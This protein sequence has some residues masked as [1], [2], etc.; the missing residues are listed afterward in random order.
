MQAS[1]VKVSLTA[2]ESAR[3]A[4]SDELKKEDFFARQRLLPVGTGGR[5][6]LTDDQSPRYGMQLLDIVAPF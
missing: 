2:G 6:N 1:A 3:I 4:I 5:G